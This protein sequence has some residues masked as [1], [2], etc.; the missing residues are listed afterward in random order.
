MNGSTTRRRFFGGAALLAAPLA[1]GTAVAGDDL[2]ARLTALEDANTIRALL[3]DWVRGVLAGV[4]PAPAANICGFTLDADVAI[5]ADE[6]GSAT[7]S[8]ACIVETAIPIDGNETLVEMAR[9]QGEG[10]VRRVERRVLHGSFVQR[11]GGWHLASTELR[12]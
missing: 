3:R 10:F 11:D 8:V 5:T 12:A 9:L 6:N 7:A 2:A 4:A 1:A